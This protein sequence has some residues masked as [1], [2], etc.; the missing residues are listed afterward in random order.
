MGSKAFEQIVKFLHS[1]KIKYGKA[2]DSERIYFGVNGLVHQSIL[3]IVDKESNVVQFRSVQ[4]LDEEDLK[5]YHE[6]EANRVKLLEYLLECNYTWKLGK[7]ALDPADPDVDLYFTMSDFVDVDKGIDEELMDRAW[8]ILMGPSFAASAVE[9]AIQNIKSILATGE[10]VEKSDDMDIPDGE[11]PD[12]TDLKEM[13]NKLRMELSAK[14]AELIGE[15]KVD[16]AKMIL[17]QLAELDKQL[18]STD[19]SIDGI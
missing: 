14:A 11:I 13:M 2:E 8:N 10:K 18:T 7:F 15:G 9:E 5:N 6:K 19:D 1:K 3:F 16:E 4:I 12:I 17:E